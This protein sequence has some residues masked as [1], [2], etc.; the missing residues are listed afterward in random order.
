MAHRAL[1]AF[2]IFLDRE[3]TDIVPFTLAERNAIPLIQSNGIRPSDLLRGILTRLVAGTTTRDNICEPPGDAL[4]EIRKIYRFL[5]QVQSSSTL[6]STIAKAHHEQRCN[7][8][9]NSQK[10]ATLISPPAG[11]RATT[12]EKIGTCCHLTARIFWDIVQLCRRASEYA[13]PAYTSDLQALR[14]VL[15]DIDP[16]PWVHHAPEV[17]AWVAFT[18]AAAC[19]RDKDTM[20]VMWT[21]MRFLPGVNGTELMLLR[22]G[23]QYFKW[24]RRARKPSH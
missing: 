22:E 18:A 19:T 8:S 20:E 4:S 21:P 12:T 14:K 5:V 24:L 10:R 3:I 17:Y 1:I 9:G 11:E 16:I 13:S 23:W 2:S 15:S 6:E 7:A